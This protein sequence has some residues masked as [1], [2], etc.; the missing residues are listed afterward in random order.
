MYTPEVTVHLIDT[1]G[2][3]DTDKSEND[4][5]KDVVYFMENLHKN[6]IKLSGIIFLHDLTVSAFN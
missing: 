2:F 3:D 6:N 4:I 5:L 1:P